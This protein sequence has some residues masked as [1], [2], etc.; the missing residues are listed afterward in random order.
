MSQWVK[1]N[2]RP[3][4]SISRFV[5]DINDYNFNVDLPRNDSDSKINESIK[6]LKI[7]DCN[8]SFY[9]IR[10]SLNNSFADSTLNTTNTYI[11]EIDDNDL[12][13]DTNNTVIELDEKELRKKLIIRKMIVGKNGDLVYRR[14]N[15]QDE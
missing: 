5:I 10:D 7:E 15:I 9:S 2:S 6:L 12:I 14:R 3:T 11:A 4:N 1:N 13:C 8:E